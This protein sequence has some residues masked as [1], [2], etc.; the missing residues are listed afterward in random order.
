MAKEFTYNIVKSVGTF[1]NNKGWTKE[2]NV[3][4]Y[5]D[6]APKLDIR[7][8]FTDENGEKKMSKGITISPEEFKMFK[9]IICSITPDD[10]K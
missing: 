2:V 10:I 9:D 1:S 4:K 7:S 8:W 5:G 6:S 3:I